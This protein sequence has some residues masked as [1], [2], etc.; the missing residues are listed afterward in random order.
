[1]PQHTA[2]PE[3]PSEQQQPHGS[4]HRPRSRVLWIGGGVA[5]LLAVGG[6]TAA[7]VVPSAKAGATAGAASSAAAP[8][9]RA[10]RAAGGGAVGRA[11]G[12]G[13]GGGSAAG[14]VHIAATAV[15]SA[16]TVA[17]VH[18]SVRSAPAA[19][20]SSAAAVLA[21]DDSHYRQQLATGEGLVGKTGFAAW[22]ARALADTADQS[23][24]TKAQGDFTAKDQPPA[25]IAWRADEAQA[26][27][28]V[29]QFARDSRGGPSIAGRTDAANALTYLDDA[30]QLARQVDAGQ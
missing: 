29:Q 23:D 30:D 6:A 22:A 26:V 2:E 5:L 11:H 16:G 18:P 25:L 27:D 12:A 28:A 15:A 13:A 19:A 20:R 24:F 17:L 9:A 10:S 1:M 14:G 4:A 21:A 3:P 7:V 8:S